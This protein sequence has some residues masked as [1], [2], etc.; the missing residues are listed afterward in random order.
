MHVHLSLTLPFP[1]SIFVLTLS[2]IQPLSLH[3][4]T[5]LLPD[6]NLLALL[7]TNGL[8]EAERY[9]IPFLDDP[10]CTLN[11]VHCAMEGHLR[12]FPTEA[13]FRDEWRLAAQKLRQHLPRATLV[14]EWEQSYPIARDLTFRIEA[15]GK[16]LVA[17]SPLLAH[18]VARRNL[19]SVEASIFELAKLHDLQGG[20]LVTLAA[21]ACLYEQGT[22]KGAGG[23]YEGH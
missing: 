15:E 4:G 10:S 6:K 9:W 16:F 13:E 1:A 19:R 3:S 23:A 7:G 12:R 14:S 8:T 11:P 22:K 2:G 5:V 20:G 17:V 21:L 18:Q